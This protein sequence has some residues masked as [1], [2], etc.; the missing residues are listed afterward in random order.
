[1]LLRLTAAA[2]AAIAAALAFHPLEVS[3]RRTVCNLVARLSAVGAG[4]PSAAH[5]SCDQ[6]NG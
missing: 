4:G 3:H 1:V 5:A 6:A 2:P